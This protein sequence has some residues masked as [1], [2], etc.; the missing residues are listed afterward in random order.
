M[1]VKR[2]PCP[3]CKH[4]IFVSIAGTIIDHN[5]STGNPCKANGTIVDANVLDG[6][7]EH[8]QELIG[9]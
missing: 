8:H 6:Y 1:K 5:D 9:L 7:A 4:P 2:L 3:I